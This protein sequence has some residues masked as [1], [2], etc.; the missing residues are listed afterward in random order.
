MTINKRQKEKSRQEK[1]RDKEQKRRDR[2]DDKGNKI[3]RG[4]GRRSGYC[5]YRSRAAA[6]WPEGFEDD[7]DG[8][9]ERTTR[10]PETALPAWVLYFLGRARPRSPL[11]DCSPVL[12]FLGATCPQQLLASR[13]LPPVLASL[14]S[15]KELEQA[16]SLT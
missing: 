13:L 14:G 3:R 7:V 8:E 16:V 10:Y 6:T 9:A 5:R 1:Q 2:R 11:R 15:L 4:T 12:E